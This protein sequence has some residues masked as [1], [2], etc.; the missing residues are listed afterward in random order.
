MPI[1]SDLVAWGCPVC[2]VV[3]S[4][5]AEPRECCGLP[6]GPHSSAMLVELDV[7]A[8]DSPTGIRLRVGFA[9][10]LRGAWEPAAE[11]ATRTSYE[12]WALESLAAL[13]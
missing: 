2:C 9:T 6:V 3:R 7:G 5:R 10:M 13:E 4:A 11:A 8:V 1:V 12:A